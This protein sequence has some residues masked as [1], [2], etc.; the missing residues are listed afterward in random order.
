MGMS[1]QISIGPEGVVSLLVGGAIAFEGADQYGTPEQRASAL[2]LMYV[3]LYL[4]L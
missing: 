3:S 1:R 2:A 4:L